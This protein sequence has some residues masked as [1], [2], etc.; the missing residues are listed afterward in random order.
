MAKAAF[1]K[2]QTLFAS[3]LDLSSKKKLVKC[4]TWNIVLYGAVTWTLRKVA[5][6]YFGSSEMCG[7][8][9]RWKS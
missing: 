5:Q 6:K 2:K 7:A 4:Y 8:G 9:E 3:K 1:N